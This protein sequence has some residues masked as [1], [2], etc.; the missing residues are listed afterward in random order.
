MVGFP[1]RRE[2]VV[3]MTN[4][5]NGSELFRS[6]ILAVGRALD[7][8]DSEPLVLKPAAITEA[9]RDAILGEY[10]AG[11]MVVTI[12]VKDG[13]LIATQSNSGASEI[14][15]L[16][17]GVFLAPE[18]GVRLEFHRD[19]GSGQVTEMSAGGIKFRKTVVGR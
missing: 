7:W 19:P 18:L 12:A 10:V 15:P 17:A 14:I 5:D 4:S 8:P 6:A 16:R 1:E 3:I 2:A 13:R 11:P 9:D